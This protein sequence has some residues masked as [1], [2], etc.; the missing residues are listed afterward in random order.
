MWIITNAGNIFEIVSQVVAVSAAIAAM[1]PSPK[2]DGVVAS[3]R[4]VV[5]L[6]GF[7]FG[8]AKNQK[9]TESIKTFNPFF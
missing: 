5:D 1:T 7:N 3:V 4:K 2:D 8:F 9:K 6:L